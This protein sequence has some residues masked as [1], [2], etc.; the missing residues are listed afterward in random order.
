M[1]VSFSFCPQCAAP[2]DQRIPGGD[3]RERDVC[4]RCG[5]VF[6][7]NPRV[8]VGCIATRD[9]RILLCRRAIAPRAGFWTLPA[10]FLELNETAAEAGVRETYE[11]CRAEVDIAALFTF[12]NV[13]HIGQIHMFYRA[14]MRDDRH[15]PGQEST[16]T[17]LVA[18]ADIPWRQ[19]AFPSIYRTLERYLDDREHGAFGVHT[20]DLGRT[21]WQAMD[22]DG[23]SP[24][25]TPSSG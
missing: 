17:A 19:L 4:S 11:E 1:R 10:G 12:I 16:E 13:A 5:T 6:Y 24:E 15:A 18:A 8:V 3:D 7:H 14:A 9:D 22:L 25:A 23:T 21:D 20:E 2:I